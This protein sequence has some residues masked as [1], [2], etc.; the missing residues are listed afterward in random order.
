ML[1]SAVGLLALVLNLILHGE[2]FKGVNFY[3]RDQDKKQLVF[4]RYTHFLMAANCYF[5]V[6]IAWGFLDAHHE[7]P[8]LY[9]FLYL[10]T[11]LYFVFM[12]TTMLMWAR[13][14]VA[15]LDKSGRRSSL[16][17]YGVWSMFW[18]GLLC[19]LLNHVRPFVFSFDETYAYHAEAGRYLVFLFQIL[20]YVG[21]STYMLY[22]A[23]KSAGQKRVKYFAVA[24]TSIGMGLFLL[25][26]VYN[27]RL[28]SYSMGL[29]IGI[30]VIHSFVELGDRKEKAI[31][32]NIAAAMAS[33]YEVIYYI[34]LITNEYL[35][36]STSNQYRSMNVP[37]LGKDFFGEAKTTIDSF[38]YPDDIE[39]ALRFYD[40]EYLLTN[41][42]GK[43]SFSYKYRVLVNGE[44][45]YFLF[46]V[47]YPSDSHYLIFYEKDIEDELQAEKS[48]KESQKKT[49]TFSQIAESLASNYDE[50][51]YVK[52]EDDSYVCYEVNNIYGQL[53]LSKTGKDFF[54]ESQENIPQVV[55]KHDRDMLIEFVNKDYLIS[56]L[57]SHRGCSIDYRIMVSGKSRYT[58]MSVR[59]TSDGTHFIIGVENIDAEVRKEKQRQKELKTEKELAR[60][61]ELTGVKN[62][63]AYK[64]LEDSVQS[65]MDNG[66][67][68]LPFAL[69]VCDAN[70][71]KQIND[72]LGHAAGDE[73]IK[74]SAKIL[75]DIFVHSPVFR[76][77][78]DEF[79]VFL[80]GSD[81]VARVDLMEKLRNIV[82]ENQQNGT[83]AVLASGMTE[84]N[85]ERDSFVAEIFDRADKEM[86]ENKQQLKKD[87]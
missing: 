13:Y 24:F 73:Y 35:E 76:I 86:Y 74:A 9:P 20:F 78:G 55:Q 57:E 59:K 64:E 21:T 49:I 19:L 69:V 40:K 60:R 22:I 81:Y 41:L 39:Y 18:F 58:R 2:S 32:D 63:T 61:D 51:Y 3:H 1:Y 80:R 87:F 66:M 53:E 11:V 46:T 27:V 5:V 8:G 25:I 45:R 50:I 23:L 34:D 85:P 82:L 42:E 12:L 17:L 37:S 71:L 75:C 56:S 83:G 84:Y 47:M 29:L 72:T 10:D 14:V 6:D 31:H 28:P 38:V 26:Q 7:I 62:K 54:K 30:A 33:D 68:Y 52:I 67:D 36:F 65:N 79:V 16:L 77:G 48:R 70:N 43:H 15:Y 44:P 4:K